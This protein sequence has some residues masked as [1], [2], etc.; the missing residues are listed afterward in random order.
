MND[1]EQQIK[2]IRETVDSL[3]VVLANLRAH[4]DDLEADVHPVSDMEGG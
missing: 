1:A 2:H 3:R 4:L